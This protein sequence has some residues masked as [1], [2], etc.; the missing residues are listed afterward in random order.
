[1]HD[2]VREMPGDSARSIVWVRRRLS[3][4]LMENRCVR[5]VVYKWPLCDRAQKCYDII[6]ENATVDWG[7]FGG[8][9][10]IPFV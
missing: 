4:Q 5:R 8:R 2:V 9:A 3:W 10:Q 1:M 7:W 6:C